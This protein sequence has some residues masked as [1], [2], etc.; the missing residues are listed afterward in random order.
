[1]SMDYGLCKGKR[2]DGKPCTMPVNKTE[3]GGFCEFHVVA[4]FNRAKRKEPVANK[5]KGNTQQ[6]AL[7]MSAKLG[8]SG[9][10]CV[11]VMS[12]QGCSQPTRCT[13]EH[14]SHCRDLESN[15]VDGNNV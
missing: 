7:S 14:L 9:K 12:A 1:M 4:A 6:P 2:K 15:S 5:T 3:G 11:R 8:A 10:R 13:K